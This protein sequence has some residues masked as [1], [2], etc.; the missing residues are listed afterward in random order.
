M[1]NQS[2]NNEIEVFD[3]L[4]S[5]LADLASNPKTESGEFFAKMSQVIES[6]L[7]PSWLAVTARGPDESMLLIHEVAGVRS[8]L[9]SVLG[10]GTST[11][12]SFGGVVVSDIDDLSSEE[13]WG[14][15]VVQLKTDSSSLVQQNVLNAIAE[16]VS[17]FVSR[18]VSSSGS[19]SDGVS[20]QEELLRFSLNAHAS[21]EKREVGHHLANDIRMLL[22]CERVTVF[23]VSNRKPSLLAISSV[24]SIEKR[25]ELVRNL[26]GLVARAIRLDEPVLSDQPSTDSRQ[27]KLLD[28]H[29]QQ[30]QLPFVFGIPLHAPRQGNS[31]KAKTYVGFLLMEST[32]EIDRIKFGQGISHAGPHAATSLT[33]ANRFSQIP[34]RGTLSWFGRMANLAN[35][36]FVGAF[37]GLIGLIALAMLL[38]QTDFKVRIPGELKPVVERTVFAPQDGVVDKIFVSHGD[39]VKV[40]EVLVELRSADLELELENSQSDIAKLKQLKESKKIALNQAT[41]I[42]DS[43]MAAQLASEVSDLDFQVA[44]VL[45]KRLFLQ[46]QISELRIVCPIAG[47]ITTWQAKENLASRPVR[48]GDPLVKI[49]QLSGEWDLV[50]KVPERRI[51]YIIEGQSLSDEPLELEFFLDSN[52]SKKYRV[53]VVSIDSSAIQDEELGTVT[54]L[55][56][57]APDDLLT[58]RQGAVVSGD[59]DCGRRSFWFVFTREVSDAIRRRFVW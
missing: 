28:A 25:S 52:P 19:G 54:L 32:E 5:G 27:R 50:F 10:A 1:E 47:E 56:C 40:D 44:T 46:E 16:S 9:R 41:N 58:K 53:P 37:I 24:A 30:T 17:E 23:S 18:Q 22:N 26:N 48:W 12:K 11:L 42:G 13:S 55:R 45:E 35:L 36:S 4:I 38:F 3:Q 21:L 31:N 6:I 34:F 8:G 20:Y 14:Y 2:K 59:V 29:R 39:K 7:D 57:K 49:A 15:L 33:N 43:A 51:G